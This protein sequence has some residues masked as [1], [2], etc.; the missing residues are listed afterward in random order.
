[1]PAHISDNLIIH[2]SM[3]AISHGSQ[4]DNTTSRSG[5]IETNSGDIEAKCGN[6]DSR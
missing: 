2:I 6:T 4:K 3:L 5:R 1:M